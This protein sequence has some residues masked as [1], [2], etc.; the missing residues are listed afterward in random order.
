[1]KYILG[2]DLN[3]KTKV[4]GANGVCERILKA[5]ADRNELGISSFFTK[6]HKE[7]MD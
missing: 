3:K 7:C 4:D 6:F 5:K 1:M 2:D